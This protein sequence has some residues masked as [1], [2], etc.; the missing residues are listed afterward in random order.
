MKKIFSFYA[1]ATVILFAACKD[2]DAKEQESTTSSTTKQE[3]NTTSNNDNKKSTPSFSSAVEYNDYI[4]KMQQEIIAD[5]L[6]FSSEQNI[7]KVEQIVQDAVP[8]IENDI[9]AIANMPDWKGNTELRDK[10]LELF[11]FYKE[12]FSKDYMDII[13]VSKDGKVTEAEKNKILQI[14][15]SITAKEAKLDE[16]FKKAQQDFARSNNMIIA[17]N[18]MQKDI[19]NL[20]K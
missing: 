8:K 9:T 11:K 15:T 20:N 13:N 5:V 7:N 14:Q 16:A 18:P 2:K 10:S 4:V 6:K 1:I 3:T 17:D 19:D 12:T